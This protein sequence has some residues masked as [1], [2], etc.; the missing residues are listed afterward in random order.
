[1]GHA[2]VD[3]G[4]V[5][6]SIQNV[7]LLGLYDGF[8]APPTCVPE[9]DNADGGNIALFLNPGA[10]ISFA[11]TPTVVVVDVQGIGDNPPLSC[12]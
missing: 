2:A 5:V 12:S 10:R 4:N 9:P 1:L 7:L 3:S 6:Q 11:Q 8:C